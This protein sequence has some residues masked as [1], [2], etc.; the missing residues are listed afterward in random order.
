MGS[1]AF[2]VHVVASDS[3]QNRQP[4]RTS[5]EVVI[6]TLRVLLTPLAT[7]LTIAGRKTRSAEDTRAQ[8]L[9]KVCLRRGAS[10]P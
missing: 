9:P 5:L 4:A 6:T 8:Q 10:S 7:T 3:T 2:F 1:K